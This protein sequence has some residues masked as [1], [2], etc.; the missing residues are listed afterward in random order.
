MK[1]LWHRLKNIDGIEAFGCFGNMLAMVELLLAVR[2]MNKGGWHVAF[3][4]LM[5]VIA[6]WLLTCVNG[7]L[8]HHRRCK[9]MEGDRHWIDADNRM[10]SKQIQLNKLNSDRLELADQKINCVKEMISA[11]KAMIR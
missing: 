4:F 10:W 6:G 3:A 5:A 1:K 8:Y 7:M 9:E 11:L 2:A